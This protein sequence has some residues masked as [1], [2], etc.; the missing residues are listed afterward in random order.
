MPYE[1]KYNTQ[2]MT[3][4]NMKKALYSSEVRKELLEIGIK[5]AD[6]FL[7]TIQKE[8]EKPLDSSVDELL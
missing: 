4:E 8:K 7:L 3:F 5:S 2:F 1:L 6:E